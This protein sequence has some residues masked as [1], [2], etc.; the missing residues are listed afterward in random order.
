MD[1]TRTKKRNLKQVKKKIDQV[2]IERRKS[3]H[4]LE[5]LDHDPNLPKKQRVE[6]PSAAYQC[7]INLEFMQKLKTLIQEEPEFNIAPEKNFA[8][9]HALETRSRSQYSYAG[10]VSSVNS[11]ADRSK[12]AQSFHDQDYLLRN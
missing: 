10:F 7:Y 5:I 1:G 6:V 3:A 12:L 4:S 2:K 8:A 11:E 9:T